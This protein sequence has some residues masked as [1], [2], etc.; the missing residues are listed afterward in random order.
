MAEDGGDL[1]TPF[2]VQGSEEG[3]R[4]NERGDTPSRHEEIRDLEGEEMA[5]ETRDLHSRL[6]QVNGYEEG[7]IEQVKSKIQ[8]FV[9]PRPV[10]I[11]QVPETLLRFQENAYTPQYRWLSLSYTVE[12]VYSPTRLTD[13]EMQH[14]DSILSR[15]KEKTLQHYLVAMNEFKDQIKMSHEVPLEVDLKQL[16]YLLFSGFH[17]IDILLKFHEKILDKVDYPCVSNIQDLWMDMLLVP[18]QVP[19][20]ALQLIFDMVFVNKS[21]YPSLVE[22]CLEFFSQFVTINKNVKP[23]ESKS[24]HHLLH[25]VHHHLRPSGPQSPVSSRSY[26]PLKIISSKLENLFSS[27]SY[28]LPISKNNKGQLPTTLLKPISTARRLTMSGVHFR[29]N[30]GDAFTD[31]TFKKGVLEIPYL[32]INGNTKKLLLNLAAWEQCDP[33]VGTSF[34]SYS[35]FMDYVINTE[36]DVDILIKSGILLHSLGVDEEVVAVFNKLSTYLV[37]RWEESFLPQLSK[38]VN[39]YCGNKY[40]TWW[41][42]LMND[43]FGSPW[44]VISLVAAIFLLVLNVVQ[45]IFS[46]Y[47]F[48]KA[49]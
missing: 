26:N 6:L 48:I 1:R 20:F 30:E 36:K 18:Y 39:D 24:V 11:Y 40:N 10:T 5:G 34:T 27:R 31:I 4:A 35:I 13:H 29:R 9:E 17:I 41:A 22:L 19:F 45:S 14:V 12:G 7:Y 37:C 2:I 44:S 23:L 8:S 49:T 47:G 38:E 21:A 25:L 15:N 16:L 42:K 28:E 3:G 46:I 33:T 32:Q 43:Y